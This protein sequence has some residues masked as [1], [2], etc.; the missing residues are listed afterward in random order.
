MASRGSWSVCGAVIPVSN[1]TGILLALQPLGLSAV[2]VFS[3]FSDPD[4]I[5][6]KQKWNAQNWQYMIS[7]C[8]FWFS[9]LPTVVDWDFHI[10]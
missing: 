7:T 10:K 5:A 9:L 6:E 1:G 8:K 2:V 3:H 4:I